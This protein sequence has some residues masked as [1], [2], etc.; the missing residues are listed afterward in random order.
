[1]VISRYR[2]GEWHSPSHD[3]GEFPYFR[4]NDIRYLCVS[5][6]KKI[7]HKLRKIICNYE[8]EG[9]DKYIKKFSK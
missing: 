3:T 7:G 6:P 4:N 1:M 8:Y 9:A 5:A 2:R